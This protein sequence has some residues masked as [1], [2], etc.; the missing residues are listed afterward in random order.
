MWW[1]EKGDIYIY[2]S[3]VCGLTFLRSC[4][5]TQQKHRT[6][7][8]NTNG[9]SVILCLVFL[10]SKK[11]TRKYRKEEKERNINTKQ[12]NKE[13]AED[14]IMARRKRERKKRERKRNIKRERKGT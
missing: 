4:I 2:L 10:Q 12:R 13:K 9:R 3:F 6:T 8:S 11:P 14:M 1:W 7:N 5:T